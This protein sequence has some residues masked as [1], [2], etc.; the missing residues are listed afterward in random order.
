MPQPGCGATGRNAAVGVV[1]LIPEPGINAAGYFKA[2]L[3]LGESGRLFLAVAEAAGEK[4]ATYSVGAHFNR[5]EHPFEDLGGGQFP[6]DLNV[7]CV[8][9][10]KARALAAE[11]APEFGNRYT[12]GLWAWE[13]AEFPPYMQDGFQFVDEVWAVSRFTADAIRAVSPR[14]VYVLPPP[15]VVPEQS[16]PADLASFGLPAAPFMFLFVFD[17]HSTIDRKNP[18]GLIEAFKKAVPTGA[19]P[20]LVIKSINGYRVPEELNRLRAAVTKAPGVYLMEDYLDAGGLRSLMSLCDC[21]VSLHRSEGFGLTLAEAMA[22]GKPV[23]AT[24]YSGNLEFMNPGN[25]FLVDYELGRVPSGSGPYQKGASWAD[26]DLEQAAG[27]MRLVVEDPAKAAARAARGYA[28]V[29]EHHSVGDRAIALKSRLNDLRASDTA[30][31]VQLRKNQVFTPIAGESPYRKSGG[32]CAVWL[33][34][35]AARGL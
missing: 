4:L 31:A 30:A 12:V 3:G 35:S 23:I 10:D 15:V 29:R 22:L 7:F 32:P 6:Y 13:L 28:D 8:N 14:P 19:G 34:D 20:I 16:E 17:F 2:E 21:Y 26:P 11:L 5:Q 9:G 33:W 27:F 25:S 24:G 1:T 18:L